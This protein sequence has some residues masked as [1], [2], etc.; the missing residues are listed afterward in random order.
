[1][2]I[3]ENDIKNSE[4][5]RIYQNRETQKIKEIIQKRCREIVE[6]ESSDELYDIMNESTEKERNRVSYNSDI[7]KQLF[8]SLNKLINKDDD[9][10]TYIT[11]LSESFERALSMYIINSYYEKL[12]KIINEILIHSDDEQNHNVNVYIGNYSATKAR[13]LQLVKNISIYGKDDMWAAMQEIEGLFP[14]DKKEGKTL[15]DLM[16]TVIYDYQGNVI[17]NLNLN[18]PNIIEPLDPNIRGIYASLVE[19]R[20]I[21]YRRYDIDVYKGRTDKKMFIKSLR[22]GAS[23]GEYENVEDGLIITNTFDGNTKVLTTNSQNGVSEFISPTEDKRNAIFTNE[24]LREIVNPLLTKLIKDQSLS[25]DERIFYEILEKL[26]HSL[27]KDNYVECLKE[28]SNENEIWSEYVKEVLYKMSLFSMIQYNTEKFWADILKENNN[29]ELFGAV[30]LGNST[31]EYYS[32][33]RGGY[34]RSQSKTDINLINDNDALSHANPLSIDQRGRVS[35]V[36]TDVK[37]AV[38][39]NNVIYSG[40]AIICKN[41]YSPLTRVNHIGPS[42]QRTFRNGGDYTNPKGAEISFKVSDWLQC[43]AQPEYYYA[44]ARD[45]KTQ[46]KIQEETKNKTNNL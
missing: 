45:K 15:L 42:A 29:A 5:E 25:M 10:D 7:Y 3:D 34:K 40:N 9:Y 37:N 6:S 39:H 13:A 41:Q 46:E 2:S 24:K 27:G 35:G 14:S 20:G 19:L 1:M 36:I 16:N 11:E 38:G 33:N 21:F 43:L 28:L 8:F 30:F 44:I 31:Y 18:N 12:V 26:Y 23:H 4:E 32:V 22:D 17:G